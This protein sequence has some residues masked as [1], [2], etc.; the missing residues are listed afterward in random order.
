MAANN[1]KFKSRHKKT[2]E[3]KNPDVHFNNLNQFQKNCAVNRELSQAALFAAINNQGKQA[4]PI[5]VN[6]FKA[7]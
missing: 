3:I 5:K 7:L 2:T 6:Y 1:Y 4:S